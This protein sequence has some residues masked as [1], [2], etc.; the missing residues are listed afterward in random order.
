MSDREV[1]LGRLTTVWES[2][3]SRVGRIEP[4]AFSEAQLWALFTERLLALGGQV[5]GH[6][7]LADL[8]GRAVCADE[9]VAEFLPEGALPT[10][11]PWKAEVGV[12]LADWAIAETGSLL[13]ANEPGRR[14][15][16]SLCPLHH[17]ALVPADRLLATL[18][19]A[20]AR[21]GDRT[22]VLVTGPSRTA[23]IEGVLI[24]G[25]HGPGSLT[26]V[27]LDAATTRRVPDHPAER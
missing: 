26:V 27:R 22:T 16:A 11:D 19:A 20:F 2:E 6:E 12:T 24:R 1:I 8:A 3:T 9:E 18:D 15:L 23:D 4:D 10:T 13:I 17:L 21:L 7:A 5:A 14:R 25:V